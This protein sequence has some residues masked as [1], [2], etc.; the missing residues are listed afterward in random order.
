MWGITSLPIEE[1]KV[2][3]DGAVNAAKQIEFIARIRLKQLVA[4]ELNYELNVK[5]LRR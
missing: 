2:N 3:I 4:Q 1:D 5:G